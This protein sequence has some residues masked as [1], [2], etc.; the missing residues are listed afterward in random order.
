MSSFPLKSGP[1]YHYLGFTSPFCKTPSDHVCFSVPDSR[2]HV[3]DNELWAAAVLLAGKQRRYQPTGAWDQAS[4]AGDLPPRALLPHDPLLGLRP[5]GETQLHRAGG[6]DQVRQKESSTG[7]NRSR[8]GFR[9]PSKTQHFPSH[10]DVQKMEKEQEL[11]RE[12]DRAR[13][14]KLFEP[15]F[16]FN[17]PPPKVRTPR[18]TA[19]AA[20]RLTPPPHVF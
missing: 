10:S 19:S 17:E 16:N 2:V 14:T 6:Q 9:T 12:R 3:G 11:E 20:G 8:L 13:A 4:Q 7:R 5:Q 15:K 18:S 1:R